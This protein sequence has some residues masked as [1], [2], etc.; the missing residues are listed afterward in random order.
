[1]NDAPATA[2]H[3]A[4]EITEL[5]EVWDAVEEV[6]TNLEAD[7]ARIGLIR[8]SDGAPR[9]G[10]ARGTRYRSGGRRNRAVGGRSSTE[11]G[12]WWITPVPVMSP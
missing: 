4:A 2:E 11:A 7:V 9:A 10:S 3:L 6:D 8:I 12:H 1:M 5:T